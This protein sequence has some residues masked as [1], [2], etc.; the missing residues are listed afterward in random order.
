MTSLKGKQSRSSKAT[1]NTIKNEISHISLHPKRHF[2]FDNGDEYDGEFAVNMV[3]RKIVR[4]GFGAYTTIS[5]VRF[6]GHWHN[7]TLIDVI[8]ILYPNGHWFD[9]KIDEKLNAMIGTLFLVDGSKFIGEF[10]RNIAKDV[11]VYGALDFF[12]R[13]ERQ[14][15]V[16]IKDDVIHLTRDRFI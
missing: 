4:H 3:N 2:N 8:K 7:D 12:D 9:G 15:N 5:C 14:W 10:S 6:E 1:R 13:N 11:T 16:E